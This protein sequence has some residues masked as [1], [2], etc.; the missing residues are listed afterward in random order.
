MGM[1]LTTVGIVMVFIVLLIVTIV[2]FVNKVRKKP[3]F[4][5]DLILVII[6]GFVF[7]GLIAVDINFAT[8]FLTGGEKITAEQAADEAARIAGKGLVISFDA[9]KTQWNKR[10]EEK[11]KNIDI[12]VKSFT[13][14]EFT[15]SNNKKYTIKVLIDNKNKKEESMP[16]SEMVGTDYLFLYDKDD[17]FHKIDSFDSE[18]DLLPVG[19]SLATLSAYV[20]KDV[21]ILGMKLVD[22]KMPFEK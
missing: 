12:T 5:R 14:K 18:S 8:D 7:F 4:K 21:N 17:I 1:I 3:T 15:K 10:S 19:K 13:E 22:R 20:A 2:L 16:L 6:S 9:I 11:L